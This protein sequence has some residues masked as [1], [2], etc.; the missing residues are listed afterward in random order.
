LAKQAG[1]VSAESATEAVIGRYKPVC[2]L[3]GVSGAAGASGAGQ[4]INGNADR[5]PSTPYASQEPSKALKLVSGVVRRY[6]VWGGRTLPHDSRDCSD[7]GSCAGAR[8]LRMLIINVYGWQGSCWW[9]QTAWDRHTISRPSV[10]RL[11]QT[12]RHLKA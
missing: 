1:L 6:Y 3:G 11:P 5:R 10:R 12:N 8:R 9:P 7:S 4:S 2:L